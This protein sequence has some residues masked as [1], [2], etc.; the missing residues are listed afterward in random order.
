MF[1]EP[2]TLVLLLL[3]IFP[4]IQGFIFNF[5]SQDL[6]ES[7]QGVFGSVAFLTSL[8]LGI[9]YIKKIFIQHNEGMYQKIYESIPLQA[10]EFIN[11]KPLV[12]YVLFMPIVVLLIYSI[13]SYVVN[14]ISR[15][16]FYPLLD[17]IENKLKYKSVF[18]K[19][20]IGAM[21][22]VPRAICYVIVITFILNFLSFLKITD[23]YNKY[24]E[25]SQLYN[26]I[27]KQVVIPLTNSK[28]AKQLPNIVNNSFK[29]VVKEVD[30]TDNN[31]Q[32]SLPNNPK[33]IT[34]Y[35]GV[36]LEQGI[37]SNAEIDKFGVD[38]ASGESGTR[39]KAKHIY[40]WVGSEIVYDDEKATR[41]LNNDL[42]VDS[43]AIPTFN[44]R[45]GICF[46]YA[47]LFVAMSKANNIKV[48]I[49]TGQGFNG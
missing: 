9:Y 20:I 8:F 19:R 16:T 43:G 26:Y 31:L 1:K 47:C 41:V 11:S 48:R 12:I 49:I 42:K 2:L 21:F 17:T 33:V 4:I 7:I 37:K 24:L 5:S 44:S 38:L 28:I 22:Q 34:Y 13:I 36:T 46:D 45:N 14:F 35:N 3:F 18:S 27:S 32:N 15:I 30:E 10:I 40:K 25:E 23:T 6:K 29:I 39:E